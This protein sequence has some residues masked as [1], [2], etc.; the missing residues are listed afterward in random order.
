M[1]V[2]SFSSFFFQYIAYFTTHACLY[3]LWQKVHGSSYPVPLPRLDL[4]LC[5]FFEYF[6][7]FF[8]FPKFKCDRLRCRIFKCL[9]C[10]MFSEA[11][12]SVTR[13]LLLILANSQLSFLEFKSP[14]PFSPS[15]PSGIHVMPKLYL[16]QVSHMSWMFSSSV[17]SV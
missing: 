6:P 11:L 13:C 8:C 14:A 7:L 16:V 10:L 17:F 12:R 15:F 3:S 5:G 2:V 4:F 1:L 9:S